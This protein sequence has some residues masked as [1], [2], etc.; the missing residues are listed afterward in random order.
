MDTTQAQGSEIARLLEEIQREYESAK[1]GVSG[2]AYGTS[3][4]AFITKHMENMGKLHQE[5]GVIVGDG[6]AI[7]LIAEQ[8][9]VCSEGHASALQ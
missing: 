4:H 2:L 6:P 3:Q 1:L 5:L 7:A 8:L 9:E